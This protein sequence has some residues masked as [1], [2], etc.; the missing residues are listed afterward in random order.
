MLEVHDPRT[1]R[2]DHRLGH[3]KR[4]AV[5]AVESHGD[6]AGQLDVLSLVLAHRDLVGVV[7]QDVGGLECRIGEQPAG[8]EIR[9]I[10]LVL[11]LGHAT[12]LAERRGAL[13]HPGALGVLGEVALDEKC[14]AFGIDAD[15]DEQLGQREGGSSE[16]FGLV[17]H[18]EGVQVDHAVDGLVFVL[19]G[20]PVLECPQQV[21]E[22]NR[23]GGLDARED[24]CHGWSGYMGGGAPDGG[25]CTAPTV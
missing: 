4:L 5:P 22:V 8:H 14:A 12:E 21:A 10:G 16:L 13:H 2:R 19:H 1:R 25:P 17:R 18:G 3:H 11:E 6:V 20:H 7:Q 24:A 9:T 23:S 15:G